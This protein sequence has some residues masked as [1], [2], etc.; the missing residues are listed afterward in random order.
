MITSFEYVTVLISIV[1]GL[2][3]TQILTSAA[4]II[5]KY[6]RVTLYWPHLFWVTF[7]LFLHIQEWWVIYEVKDF[8]PWRLPVFLF[9]MLY[10][11]NLFV[12]A[13]LL[14][15]HKIKGKKIEL[16]D[17]YF[18]NY[19]KFFG[20]LIVSALLSVAYNVLILDLKWM[21]QLLQILLSIS[22]SIIVIKKYSQEWLHKLIAISV[23]SV[24]VISILVEW[25]VWL[26]T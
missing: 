5:Q 18:N 24:M 22:L 7:I 25:D 1:L 16:K 10:P 26:I 13:K 14:F 3:I 19:Q 9:V 8:K 23:V 15:P 21:D 20:V 17:F 6:E 2:G 12:L 4:V 11:I